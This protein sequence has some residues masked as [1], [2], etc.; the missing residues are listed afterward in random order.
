[1]KDVFDHI[2][3]S[4][5]TVDYSAN[6]V[7]SLSV[8]TYRQRMNLKGVGL[9]SCVQ[10]NS[11]HRPRSAFRLLEWQRTILLNL[12]YF[13]SKKKKKIGRVLHALP[14]DSDSILDNQRGRAKRAAHRAVNEQ[15]K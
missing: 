4:W 9:L 14:S 7:P 5:M 2:T 15:L 8:I 1:M 3:I 6:H 11:P 12:D 13:S 10:T